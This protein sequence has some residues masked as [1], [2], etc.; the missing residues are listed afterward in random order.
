[1]KSKKRKSTE[2]PPS[3]TPPPMK[4]AAVAGAKAATVKKE[5]SAKTVA[6]AK[7]DSSF[8]SAPKPKPKL[9]SFKKAQ[10]APV[11]REAEIA[12]PSSIDPFQ[13]ALKS[14]R[15]K[16]ESPMVS[17]PPPNSA[18]GSTNGTKTGKKRKSVTWPPEGQLEMVKYIDK[19]IYDD[20]PEDVSLL[21]VMS[22]LVLIRLQ[23]TQHHSL[24]ELDRGEGAALHAH[25]FEEAIDW[26]EPYGTSYFPLLL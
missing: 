9:P 7:S 13:E 26:F 23:G 11:K 5:S 15:P 22:C 17:T 19:A 8:F 24:Q 1:M 2:P 6:P 20:D 25:L 12:Q 3:K 14:M 4:K 21:I 10:V 18:A 16:R